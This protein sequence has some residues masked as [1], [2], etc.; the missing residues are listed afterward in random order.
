MI[1][2]VIMHENDTVVTVT[3]KVV[4]GE[5][6]SFIV[7]GKTFT[8]KATSDIPIYHKAAVQSIAKDDDVIKYGERIGCAIRDIK[9]G[10][11]VHTNNLDN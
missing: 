6:I 7:N 4:A 1:N 9:P 3:N 2:A 10:D 8:V 11:H 5:D